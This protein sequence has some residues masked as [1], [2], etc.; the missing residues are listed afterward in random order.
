MEFVSD[1][2]AVQREPT[3][4]ELTAYLQAHPDKFRVEPRFTFR[5]VYLN[6]QKHGSNLAHDAAQLLVQLN[7]AGDQAD[8]S[9]MGDA[10]MLEP[11][12]DAVPTSKVEKQ[13]GETF[14]T[15]LGGLQLGQWQGP[16]E[17]GYGVHLV[18][19]SART[20]GSL[21]ALAKSAVPCAASGTTPG[22]WKRT[23]SST[24]SC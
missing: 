5:Q 14:A 19:V 16:V 21:P 11:A 18:K 15:K 8:L 20:E 3:D 13:F 1:D 12:F 9:A 4:A 23:R 24:S 2:I 17:S 7:Q 6:P 22:S 10:L